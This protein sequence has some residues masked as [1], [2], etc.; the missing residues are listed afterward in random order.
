[1]RSFTAAAKEQGRWE[2]ICVDLDIAVEGHSRRDAES[3][4]EAAVRSYIQKALQEEPEVTR[5]LLG[6]RSPLSVR[7]KFWAAALLSQ[8]NDLA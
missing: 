5:Q 8:E 4:L 2:A 7:V 1:M 3:R 6:R